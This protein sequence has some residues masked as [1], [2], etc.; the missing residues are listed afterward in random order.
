MCSKLVAIILEYPS[1]CINRGCFNLPTQN[2]D[3]VSKGRRYRPWA[4]ARGHSANFNSSGH[5]HPCNL[6]VHPR[7]PQS[8]DDFQT[9][10]YIILLVLTDNIMGYHKSLARNY[11]EMV[12]R[13]LSLAGPHSF[14]IVRMVGNG[15]RTELGALLATTP[16][17]PRPTHTARS[18]RN[19]HCRLLH[20][21]SA[22]HNPDIW[23]QPVQSGHVAHSLQ[24]L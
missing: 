22:D 18:A 9:A 8:P 21:P 5:A 23:Q 16:C 11:F 2:N 15:N 10:Q 13:E 4:S 17:R 20:F 3:T 14:R 6:H 1:T 12:R 19:D 7:R 24:H